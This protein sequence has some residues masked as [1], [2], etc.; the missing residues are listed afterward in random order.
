MATFQEGLACSIYVGHK[1]SEAAPPNLTLSCLLKMHYFELSTF[2]QEPFIAIKR[3]I[4]GSVQGASVR[5][6]PKSL[7]REANL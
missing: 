1:A 4:P 7:G 3:F 2:C 5:Y 6:L